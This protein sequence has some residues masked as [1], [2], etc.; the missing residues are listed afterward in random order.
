M[1]YGYAIMAVIIVAEA[2]AAGHLSINV[3]N[4]QTISYLF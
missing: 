1:E 2:A 3:E 4:N